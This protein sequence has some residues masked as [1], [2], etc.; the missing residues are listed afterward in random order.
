MELFNALL[1]WK[2]MKS[3]LIMKKSYIIYTSTVPS[4]DSENVI[5]AASAMTNVYV[6]VAKESCTTPSIP[7]KT[8]A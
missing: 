7:F 1:A 4:T 6:L 8:K 2:I 3:P 5:T